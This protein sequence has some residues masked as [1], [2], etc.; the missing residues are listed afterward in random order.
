[1]VLVVV[2]LVI[3]LLVVVVLVVMVLV[4]VLTVFVVLVVVSMFGFI[5]NERLV[6]T[7]ATISML[8]LLCRLT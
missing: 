6:L 3:V 8:S 1:M 2:V 7:C 4:V 5:L